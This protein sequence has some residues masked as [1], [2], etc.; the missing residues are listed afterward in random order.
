MAKQAATQDNIV[1]KLMVTPVVSSLLNT[2]VAPVYG[3]EETTRARTEQG[4]L[5]EDVWWKLSDGR[6]FDPSR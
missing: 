5:W 6:L 1:T 2:Q 4:M 3:K